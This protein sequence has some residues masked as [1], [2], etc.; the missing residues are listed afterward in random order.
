[1]A[2]ASK[3]K[4]YA[5]LRKALLEKKGWSKD[6]LFRRVQDVKDQLPMN[7]KVATAIVAHRAGLRP[8]RFLS[9]A[10]L[11]AVQA[12]IAKLSA[13]P[14]AANNNG[15]RAPR[16]KSAALRPINFK[17]YGITTT[18]PFLSKDKLEEA[19]EMSKAYPVLYVLENSIRTVIKGVMDAK[20]GP[21]WWDTEMTS[22]KAWELRNKVNDRLRKEDQQSWHQCRGAHPIDYVDLGDLLTIARCKQEVFFP[23][24][25]SDEKWFEGLVGEASPSRNVLSHMNPLAERSVTAVS[26]KLA[27]WH[28]HLNKREAEIREAMKPVSATPSAAT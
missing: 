9:G 2:M 17:A 8:E 16:A 21:D 18:D 28:D 11:D 10:A 24:V 19:V 14:A 27:Q 13:A 3:A 5:A 4:G 7:T 26:V 25:L 15:R 22:A 6:V 1:M 20:F 12:M 23:R